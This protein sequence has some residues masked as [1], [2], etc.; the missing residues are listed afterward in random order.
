M[1]WGMISYHGRSNLLQIEGNLN[2]N[3]Y[4]REV[5]QPEVVPFLQGSPGAI[6]QQDNAHLHV[7]KTARLLFSSTRVVD[8]KYTQIYNP[9]KVERF[10]TDSSPMQLLPWPAYSPDMLPIAHLWDLVSRYLACDTCPAA[11]KELLLC[12]QVI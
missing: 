8:W 9:Q 5:L 6:F 12:I 4:V 10:R 1:V 2:S 7:A 3:R 11:S